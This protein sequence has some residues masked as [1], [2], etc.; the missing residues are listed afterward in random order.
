MAG[1]GLARGYARQP[2]LTAERFVACPFGPGGERM[3]TQVTWPSGGLTAGLRRA[4]R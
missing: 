3:Y 2:G 4:G 1:A